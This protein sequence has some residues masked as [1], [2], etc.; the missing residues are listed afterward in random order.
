MAG[1]PPMVPL[2]A[3]TETSLSSISQSES[4]V[5]PLNPPTQRHSQTQQD[6][7]QVMPAPWWLMTE[8]SSTEELSAQVM[9]QEL[10]PPVTS[11]HSTTQLAPASTTL[12]PGGHVH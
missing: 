4:Q 10:E 11:Q 1:P 7:A 5:M 8:Q 9:A 2:L 12:K 6:A 3:A